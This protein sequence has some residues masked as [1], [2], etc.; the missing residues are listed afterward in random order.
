MKQY[1]NEFTH[2]STSLSK[3]Q[4]TSQIKTNTAFLLP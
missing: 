2:N 1:G 3:R 4:M